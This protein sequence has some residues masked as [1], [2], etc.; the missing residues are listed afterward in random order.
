VGGGAGEGGDGEDVKDEKRS[1]KKL[2]LFVQNSTL[3][4]TYYCTQ[5]LMN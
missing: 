4:T 2:Q 1:L 3:N 5:Y